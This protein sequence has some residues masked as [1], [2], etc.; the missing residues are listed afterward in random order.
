MT[1]YPGGTPERWVRIAREMGR[2]VNEITAK[3]KAV[4]NDFSKYRKMLFY[5]HGSFAGLKAK[6][7]LLYHV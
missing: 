3:A 2:S 5:F 7:T 1:K 6:T 4:R